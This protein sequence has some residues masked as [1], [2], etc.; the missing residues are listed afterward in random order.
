MRGLKHVVNR[1]RN[2]GAEVDGRSA[3]VGAGLDRPTLDAALRVERECRKQDH[4]GGQDSNG[5][6]R[7]SPWCWR[8]C[9]G[10]W[11]VPILWGMKGDASSRAGIL[12]CSRRASS[13]GGG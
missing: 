3:G 12:A 7:M 11:W 1:G 2:V 8:G 13:P 9:G 5:A 4:R 10:N 6:H